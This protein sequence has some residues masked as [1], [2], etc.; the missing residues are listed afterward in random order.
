M[1]FPIPSFNG[2]QE[3]SYSCMIVAKVLTIYSMVIKAS[4]FP[5][6]SE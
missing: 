1:E 6:W 5:E 4:I 3:V 2:E